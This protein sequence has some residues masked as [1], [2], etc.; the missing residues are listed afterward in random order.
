MVEEKVGRTIK[1]GDRLFDAVNL[2]L[3]SLVMLSVLYPLYFII[4]ASFSDP[5]GIY[6][7]LV[8]LKPYKFNW[9]GY[10][11][12]F[13]YKDIWIEDPASGVG[14]QHARRVAIGEGG[15]ETTTLTHLV[16]FSSLVPIT[17]SV[18]A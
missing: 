15:G 9:E 1:G 7:G 4:I 12:I 11:A 6:Q 18:P 16:D 2:I 5:D 10:R 13:D 3:L 14:V 8:W 17:P